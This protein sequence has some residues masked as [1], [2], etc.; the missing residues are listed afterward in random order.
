MTD[1]ETFDYE[2]QCSYPECERPAIYKVA[3]PWTN[4]TVRELKTYGMSCSGHRTSILARG[5]SHREGL[6][7]A[8]GESVGRVGLYQLLPGVRD[9]ELDMVPDEGL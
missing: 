7:L 1:F 4:G 9:A 3:A 5:R 6:L 2:P 8:E